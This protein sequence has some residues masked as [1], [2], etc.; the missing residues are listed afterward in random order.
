MRTLIDLQ[1]GQLARLDALARRRGTS[2]AAIMREAI[3]LYLGAQ[4]ERD[5]D[6]AFGAWKD[7]AVEGLAR[8]RQQRSEW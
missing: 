3:E 5:A 6:E 7:N 4:G 1:Q 2:R 8:Q